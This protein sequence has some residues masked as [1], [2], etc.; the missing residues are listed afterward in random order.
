MCAKEHGR[1]LQQE[2]QTS[3][4]W[5]KDTIVLTRQ[6][7]KQWWE[8]LWTFITML[9]MAEPMLTQQTP[10]QCQLQTR[11]LLM[12]TSLYCRFLMISLSQ[13]SCSETR[14]RS[15]IGHYKTKPQMKNRDTLTEMCDA[16][17]MTNDIQLSVC[18]GGSPFIWWSKSLIT[19]TV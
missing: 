8:I 15:P 19:E 4:H 14:T 7:I 13:T 10:T 1:L 17:K 6:V 9:L 16:V 12:K 2:S 11:E 18:M 5:N 3:S